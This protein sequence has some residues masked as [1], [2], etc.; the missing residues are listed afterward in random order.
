MKRRE[1]DFVAKIVVR[2]GAYHVAVEHVPKN[3]EMS[4][5]ITA[6]SD[7]YRTFIGHFGNDTFLRWRKAAKYTL[8]GEATI[9]YIT[10]TTTTF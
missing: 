4:L 1:A 3:E 10:S 5:K 9:W 6:I 8:R 2:K 7:N